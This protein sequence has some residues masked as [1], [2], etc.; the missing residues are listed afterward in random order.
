M[1]R[2]GICCSGNWIIDHVKIIDAWPRQESLASI[3]EDEAGTGGHATNVSIDLA[4]FDLGIPL[5]GLGLVGDDADGRRIFDECDRW[6]IDRRHL[7]SERQETQP[8]AGAT[9]RSSEEN[10]GR[11]D[12]G[13]AIGCVDGEK[14]VLR[15]PLERAQEA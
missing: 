5:T 2:R 15:Q 8:K 12:F 4:R 14:T 11:I 6:G 10:P 3:F 7:R 9:A 1:A 13:D